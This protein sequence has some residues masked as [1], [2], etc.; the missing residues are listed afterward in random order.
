MLKI[1]VM[2]DEPTFVD[3]LVNEIY[4][5]C[6]LLE[7]DVMIDKFFN[8]YDLIENFSKYHLIFLDINM[9]LVDGITVAK[10]INDSKINVKW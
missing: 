4:K 7:I 8:A 3:I 10:I 2:D 1:S 5:Y 9:P 6:S